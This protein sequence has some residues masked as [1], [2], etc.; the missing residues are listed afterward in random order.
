MPNRIDKLTPEQIARMPEWVEKWTKIGL[1]T[2]EADWELSKRSIE[3][4]YKHAG[5]DPP[6]SYIMVRNPLVLALSAPIVSYVLNNHANIRDSVMDSLFDSVSNIVRDS[7][8]DN[9]WDNLFD[10]VSNSV[11]DSLFD[12]VSNSVEASVNAIVWGSVR[13]SVGNSVGNS[14]RHSVSNSVGNSVKDSVFDSVWDS[15]K[16]S[17]WDSVWDS[18]KDSVEA[19]VSNSVSH[20]VSNSVWD[21]V[22][23]S[24][25][26]SVGDSVRHSVSDSVRDS[27]RHSVRDSVSNSVSHIVG[28]SVWDS[29]RDIVRDIV[30]DSVSDSVGN[31]VRDSVSNSVRDSVLDSV[32]YS[33]GNSVS[34]SVSDSVNDSIR[35]SV[36]ATV[37]HGVG[38]IVLDSVWNSAKDIVSHSVGDLGIKKEVKQYIKNSY[39]KY[40]GGQVWVAWQSFESFF[41]DVCGLENDKKQIAEDCRNAQSS[42]FWWWP[43]K[44]FVMVCDRPSKINMEDGRLHSSTELAISWSDGWGIAAW[45]G[46]TV[47][48]EWIIGTKPTAKELL[49]WKNIEQRRAGFEIIGWDKLVS[50]L[51]AKTIDEDENPQIG[52]LIEINLPDGGKERFIQVECGTKRQFVL[53]VDPMCETILEAQAWTYGFDVNEFIKP[54]VRT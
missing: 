48:N 27:V 32:R 47:P 26:N 19:S 51:G 22:R 36:S 45:R 41:Y 14:V 30:L 39:Y 25:G 28:N 37:G 3:A 17:V 11:M 6:I 42:S 44:D 24:V 46:V 21:I 40:F 50:E 13:H 7:V 33:I 15:V 35:D 2:D 52:K 9:V 16:D 54:E 1:C 12:S 4:C 5:L 20:S 34:D 18:V 43:G 38:V 10:S 53:P 8:W 49:S 29:V 23:D 31:S